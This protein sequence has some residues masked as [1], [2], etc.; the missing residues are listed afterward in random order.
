MPIFIPIP[1]IGPRKKER[2]AR[3]GGQ[4]RI[5]WQRAWM[6]PTMEGDEVGQLLG[7]REEGK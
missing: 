6:R 3:K 7:G 5:E 2:N 4:Q 1:L